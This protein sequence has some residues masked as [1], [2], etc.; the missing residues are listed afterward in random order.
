MTNTDA[1]S[2]CQQDPNKVLATQEKEKKQKYLKACLEQC[3]HC[4]PSI[5]SIDGLLGK[6]STFA[7]ELAAKLAIPKWQCI[8]SQVCGYVQAHLS[9]AIVRATHQCLH[10]SRIPT[11]PN[12]HLMP[13]VG[14]RCSFGTL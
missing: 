6:A 9:I 4:T 2:Y 5:C 12:Q 13:I 11:Q 8:Y 7:K 1:K 10:G 3:C 14:E